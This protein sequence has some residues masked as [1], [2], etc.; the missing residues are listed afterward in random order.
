MTKQKI[1]KRC[2]GKQLSMG[3]MAWNHY[4]VLMCDECDRKNPG[5]FMAVY[6]GGKLAYDGHICGETLKI[7]HI[8]KSD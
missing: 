1:D 2:C 6:E 7:Q 4:G 8:G 3:N 5:T